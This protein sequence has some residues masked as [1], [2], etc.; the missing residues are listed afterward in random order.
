MVSFGVIKKKYWK[1]RDNRGGII[2][3]D[4][5]GWPEWS[6][7]HFPFI[8]TAC[9]NLQIHH[10]YP[11]NNI[12]LIRELPE[13]GR[14]VIPRIP[15]NFA[16]ILHITLSA[17]YFLLILSCHFFF[18]PYFFSSIAFNFC[19]RRLWLSWPRLYFVMLQACDHSCSKNHCY[20]V[21]YL[22]KNSDKFYEHQN[23]QFWVRIFSPEHTHTFSP[24]TPCL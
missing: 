10:V 20:V 19:R 5:Y 7:F 9:Y 2:I 12:V 1:N 24:P 13:K 17:N 22:V 21:N 18:P 11:Y 16:Y 4:R 3:S 14:W 8:S 15:T 23:W 6:A